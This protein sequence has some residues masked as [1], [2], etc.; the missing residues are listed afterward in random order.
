MGKL[1]KRMRALMILTGLFFMLYFGL[2]PL[3]KF[4]EEKP[5]VE[6]P[7]EV[8]FINTSECRIIGRR[9]SARFS[10]AIEPVHKLRCRMPQLMIAKTK[11]GRNV[12]VAINAQEDLKCRY[13]IQ[14]EED[15]R[16]EEY[17][18]DGHF[19][20][21]L[22]VNKEVKVGTGEQI[23]RIKC[24]NK[25]N[26]S[27]YHDVHY[28]LPPPDTSSKTR[29]T[30]EKLSVMVM[31]ID[32]TSQLH[33]LR[34]FYFLRGFV[35]SMPHTQFFGYSRVGLDAYANAMPLLSGL[36]VNEVNPELLSSKEALL[37]QIFK[38]AGYSTAYG[39]D[40]AH[41][42]LERNKEKWGSRP[43]TDFDLTPVMIA[44]DNYTRYSIDLKEM[45]HCT[46][47]RTFKSILD[48]FIAKLVPHMQDRPFFS[49]FW[50]S[51]GVEEYYEFGQKLDL[52]YMMLLKKLLDA[53]VLNN[54]L[55]FLV[56]DH[57]LRAGRY[58]MGFQGLREES[59]PLLVA[60]YPE[61]L[62]EKYPLA[63]ENLEK[64]AH[65][66]ITP[67]DLHETIKD[68]LDLDQLQNASIEVRMN[69]LLPY[70]AKR[71][72]R[73]VSLFLPI[74]DHRTCDLAH[75]PS[76]FCFCRELTEIPTDDGLV[77]RCS[78]FLVESINKMVKPLGKCRQLKLHRVLQAYFVDL[79]EESFVYELRLRIRT[80]PGNGMFEATVRLS[81][82]LLLTSPISRI[83]QYLG[84]SHCLSD[85]DLKLFCICI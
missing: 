12:L 26:E 45:L 23:V 40:V 70:P 33:F 15:I 44:M 85:P 36:S 34:Y 61:W 35:E 59:Q 51:Q 53:D 62:K 74:P 68:V 21:K 28:F 14:P 83:N 72:P 48:E 50:Q 78:R 13:W 47:G 19:E 30:P 5:V 79:G 8:V 71:T 66:L 22:G 81:D 16:F 56:S 4:Y 65:S 24:L 84:H 10:T 37:W 77:L 54:T 20:L 39:E 11:G 2:Y 38:D 41:G 49:F 60:L 7:R 18:M 29:G 58:R 1:L 82:V 57:G 67:F 3:T 42:I 69:S 75:I 76:L 6:K 64:N 43:Y 17:P 25:L 27:K 52:S 73:G 9:K 46:G 80:T 63:F 55:L 31:G 32:S